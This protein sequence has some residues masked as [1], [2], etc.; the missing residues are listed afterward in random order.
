[1]NGRRAIF[2]FVLILVV[3][4]LAP[5]V[6]AA[7]GNTLRASVGAA[8]VQ[9]TGGNSE[10]PSISGDGRYVAFQSFAGNLVTDDTNAG[11]DVFVRD[12]VSG[13]TTRVSVASD[14]TQGAPHSDS[15]S[16]SSDGRYV[17]FQSTAGNLTSPDPAGLDVFR[18]DRTTGE[19]VL[20]SVATGTGSSDGAKPSVSADGRYVAYE[21]YGAGNVPDD[22][23]GQHDIFVRD[24]VSNTT[25]RVSVPSGGGQATGGNSDS[26]SISAD[27]RYVVFQSS[28]NNLVSGDT[29]GKQDIFIHDRDSNTTTRL[30]GNGLADSQTPAISGEGRYVAFHT[31]KGLVPADTTG[32]FD[33]YLHDRTTGT[34]VLM[35][36]AHDTGAAAGASNR[37]A[38]SSDGRYVAYDSLAFNIIPGDTNDLRDIFVF[39]R[40]NGTNQRVSVDSAGN[41][42]IGGDIGET[43][44]GP[45]ISSDGVFIAF[46]SDRTNLVSGDTNGLRDV[47]RHERRAGSVITLTSTPSPSS[48]I[49]GP[50][51]T[52]TPSPSP[53]IIGP[54]DTTPPTI[55]KVSDRPDPFRPGGRRVITIR[56]TVDESALVTVVIEKRGKLIATL[57][58]RTFSAGEGKVTWKGK[59]GGRLVKRGLYSY[60]V[61]A[62]DEA[63]NQSESKGTFR[64]KRRG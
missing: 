39:D 9:A 19:T 16:I 26:A 62:V 1:M 40:V 48:T 32:G 24:M 56:F 50:D 21:G 60:R 29:N 20:V 22:T 58:G 52:P 3:G 42:G 43:F 55:T 6:S 45:A 28:A 33:M 10:Y 13:T 41:Q 25:T 17:A 46:P 53:T 49:P 31:A 12:L 38:I 15:P 51:P 4:A 61:V 35:S 23:N 47:F 14:G 11:W 54:G 5:I 44:T 63:G 18:H 34:Y 64:V 8:G 37:P 27:G 30:D 7:P 59:K 2:S 57:G 36:K